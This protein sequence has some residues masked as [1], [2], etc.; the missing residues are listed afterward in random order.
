MIPAVT[1]I[2]IGAAAFSFLAAFA[3]T[4]V[5]EGRPR[6]VR[7]SAALAAGFAVAWAAPPLL[8]APSF[9]A[10]AMD[11]ALVL[12]AILFYAPIG[13]RRPIRAEGPAERVDERDAMFS[14]ED[15]R[16]GTEIYDRYYAS[17]PELKEIDDRIRRLPALLAPGGL[18]YD[19]VRSTYADAIFKIIAGMVEMVDGPVAPRPAE[20]PPPDPARM[21][22]AIKEL[23]LHLGAS[24]VAIAP[25]DRS[26]VYSHV[27]RGPEPWG[28]P[29]DLDHR[30]AIVFTLEMDYGK[31]EQA[32]AVGIT[33]E[34]ARCYLQEAIAAVTLAQHVRDMGFPA[35]AHISGSNYQVMLPPLA[36]DAGL[37]ELGRMG[38]FISHR[39]GSRVR[40]GA[41]TT[42]LPLIPDSPGGAVGRGVREFC[43][44]CKRCAD[45][46][47]SGS[48]PDG[49][50]RVVRGVEKWPMQVEPCLH[51]WRVVG[52]DCGMCMKVCPYSHPDTFVHRAV[53]RGI[54]RS[55]FARR[56]AARAED[57]F[58]GRIRRG[59][60]CN[61]SRE[62]SGPGGE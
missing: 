44:I 11:S 33:E 20:A 56:F 51:Y 48:I 50:P 26:W 17:R 3:I 46:C 34:S 21:T 53:R 47:P 52:S 12:F 6:A 37:G 57:L 1:H 9:V 14:R 62:I 30:W 59:R 45:S 54:E 61:I 40:L 35:R 10:G 19:P 38:Y 8:G 5:R 31:V 58:Y 18:F 43:E 4:S 29:I 60:F 39:L 27:G 2:V 24:E 49:G 16:E 23:T 32:P 7:V 15:Y 13:S 36:V 42:D 55:A 28:E 22:A 41:V 25:L